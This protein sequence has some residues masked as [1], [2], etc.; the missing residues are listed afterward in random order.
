MFGAKERKLAFCLNLEEDG[1]LVIAQPAALL[2]SV[3]LKTAWK[4]SPPKKR[5]LRL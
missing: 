3:H 4:L 5:R 2:F 1:F